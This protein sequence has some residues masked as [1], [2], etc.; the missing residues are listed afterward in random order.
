M[1][2]KNE[3]DRDPRW[4]SELKPAPGN[5]RLLQ[6]FLNTADLARGSDLDSPEALA[7]WLELWGL[8]APGTDLGESDLERAIEVREAMRTL[9]AR[10]SAAAVDAAAARLDRAMAAATIRTRFGASG[11]IRFE[12]APGGL[13]GALARLCGILVEAHLEGIWQ[14]MKICGARGCGA[15][16]FDDSK[17]HSRK[18]CSPRCSSRT[19]SSAF[20]SRNLETERKR[21]RNYGGRYLI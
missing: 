1:T 6:A 21:E 4:T 13:D 16:F 9:L 3:T 14:R 15:A 8:T 11:R 18:W 20:L 2:K 17:N 10:R 12:P 19:T 7:D 5:L